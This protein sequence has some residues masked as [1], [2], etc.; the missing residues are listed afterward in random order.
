MWSGAAWALVLACGTFGSDGADAPTTEAGADSSM[1]T[2]D[3]APVDDDGAADGAPPVDAGVESG[4]VY[5]SCMRPPLSCGSGAN[6]ETVN[7]QNPPGGT[8]LSY[9]FGITTDPKYVYWVEQVEAPDAGDAYNG[10]S[11]RARIK[12]VRKGKLPVDTLADNQA[13]ATAVGREGEHVYWGVSAVAGD[14]KLMRVRH[15]CTACTPEL[16]TPVAGERIPPRR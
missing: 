14:V 3:G 5:T 1:P 16:F 10:G 13:R 6:C 9:P 15:D 4:S 8:E 11:Q 7:L 2:A 12:R